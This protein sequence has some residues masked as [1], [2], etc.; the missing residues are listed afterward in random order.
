MFEKLCSPDGR[1]GKALVV[2]VI[3]VFAACVAAGIAWKCSRRAEQANPDEDANSGI[4][5]G[6]DKRNVLYLRDTL[7]KII[8]DYREKYGRLPDTFSEAFED[9]GVRLPNRGDVYG[10][11]LGYKRTG[12]D[13]FYFHSSGRNGKNERGKGDD[14]MVIYSDGQWRVGTPETAD[15]DY[16]D[17]RRR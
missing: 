4:P 9:S 8:L 3:L 2:V 17:P 10:R 15:E 6:A 7:G 13:S 16:Y 11:P 5:A 1:S 14:L 12:S